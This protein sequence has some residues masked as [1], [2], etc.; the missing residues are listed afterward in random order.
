[1]A[2]WA[3]FKRQWWGIALVFAPAFAM[4]FDIYPAWKLLGDPDLSLKFHMAVCT[5]MWCTAFSGLAAYRYLK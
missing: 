3:F 2:A 5:L 1:V 4:S